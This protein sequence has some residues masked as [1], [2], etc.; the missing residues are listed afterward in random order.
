M[1][2]LLRN[3]A[4]LATFDLR[5]AFSLLVAADEATAD[6][7]DHHWQRIRILNGEQT[8]EFLKRRPGGN[9][10]LTRGPKLLSIPLDIAAEVDRIVNT[11]PEPPKPARAKKRRPRKR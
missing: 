11:P 7:L 8:G 10:L 5:E 4:F 6:L 1:K 2:K 9:D 3:L